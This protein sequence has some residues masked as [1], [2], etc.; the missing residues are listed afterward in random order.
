MD[1]IV[2][3][4]RVPLAFNADKAARERNAAGTNA[5]WLKRGD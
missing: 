2:L 5:M 1:L 3:S 4:F